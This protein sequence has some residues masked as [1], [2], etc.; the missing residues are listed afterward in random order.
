MEGYKKEK[1]NLALGQRL[2]QLRKLKS[3]SQEAVSQY[4]G[5]MRCT[6]YHYESGRTMPPAKILYKL[7]ALY[8]I[9]P[10]QIL[11]PESDSEAPGITEGNRLSDKEIELLYYFRKMGNDAQNDILLFSRMKGEQAVEKLKL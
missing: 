4:L 8:D 3:M 11:Y 5:I 2:K 9:P 10:E 7:A 6:Y 1:D